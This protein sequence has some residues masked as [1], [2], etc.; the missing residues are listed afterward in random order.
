MHTANV[1]T[2]YQ[3]QVTRTGGR[4]VV[5]TY[6]CD[7]LYTCHVLRGWYVMYAAAERQLSR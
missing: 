1:K 4:L 6:I 2:N 5:G 7:N 3:D